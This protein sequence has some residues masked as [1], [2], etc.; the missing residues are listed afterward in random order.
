MN[1]AIHRHIGALVFKT[2]LHE[3]T[4]KG[5]GILISPDLV[6]TGAQN[7]WNRKAKAENFDFLFYPGQS[8]ILKDPKKISQI[9]YPAEYQKRESVEEDYALLKLV[10]PVEANDFLPLGEVRDAKEAIAIFGYP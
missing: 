2:M 4:S 6:L 5:T 1:K 9:F 8:G 7:V 3:H 10:E